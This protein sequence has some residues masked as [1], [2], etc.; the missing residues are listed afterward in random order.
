MKGFLAGYKNNT[1]KHNQ[2]KLKKQ[3]QKQKKS[4]VHSPYIR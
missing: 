3:K 4:K 2:N 1:A